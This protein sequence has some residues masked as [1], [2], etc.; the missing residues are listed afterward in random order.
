[1]SFLS[2]AKLT[3]KSVHLFIKRS[4]ARRMK[5]QSLI[6][7]ALPPNTD[8][9]ADVQGIPECYTQGPPNLTGPLN[10]STC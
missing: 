8:H 2:F 10:G 5:A 1:M 9:S 6:R 7:Q 4:D 3:N